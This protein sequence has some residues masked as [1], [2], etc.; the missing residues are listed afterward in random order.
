VV[1][2]PIT[3]IDEPIT[4]V[5]EPITMVE[6]PILHLLAHSLIRFVGWEW[7]SDGYRLSFEVD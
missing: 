3:M 1:E 5:D 6:E 4:M 7:V 2:E